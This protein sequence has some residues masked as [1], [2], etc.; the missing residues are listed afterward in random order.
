[1]DIDLTPLAQVMH[2]SF[3]KFLRMTP[4]GLQF[5][6]GD[7]RASFKARVLHAHPTRTLYRDKKPVCR[8]LDGFTPLRPLHAAHCAECRHADRCTAQLNLQLSV[9]GVPYNLLLAFTSL[10]NFLLFRARL[11]RPLEKTDILLKVV[12]R[13]RWGELAFS[14]AAP[15]T[16][17]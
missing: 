17:H 1:M 6:N 11:E 8:S 13:G 14:L 3:A 7:L 9:E 15:D 10:K 2:R 16:G 5:P 4:Q 12:D